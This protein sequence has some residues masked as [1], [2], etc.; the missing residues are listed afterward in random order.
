MSTMAWPQFQ[1]VPRILEDYGVSW[2]AYHLRW[3]RLL[4]NDGS[5]ELIRI[6]ERTV[7][8]RTDNI[9]STDVWPANL[10]P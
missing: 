8:Y 6:N 3:S 9:P 5:M 1:Q 4:L 10:I 7:G 2:A